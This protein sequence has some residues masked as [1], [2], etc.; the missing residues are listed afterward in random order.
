M[1]QDEGLIGIDPA[2]G[3]AG[4]T[5][6]P[7]SMSPFDRLMKII[8]DWKEIVGLVVAIAA[9]IAWVGK[10]FATEAE[11]KRLEC[12]AKQSSI[13]ADANA[14]S[15][16]STDDIIFNTTRLENIDAAAKGRELSD[17]EKIDRK[18]IELALKDLDKTHSESVVL[19]N[20]ATEKLKLSSC[21][22]DTQ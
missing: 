6:A 22:L 9:G 12:Y 7:T 1:T 14:K 17:F 11:Q 16:Y 20:A 19:A 10:Y 3:D 13:L 15:K 4:A 21:S 8:M 18:R 5:K 2:H